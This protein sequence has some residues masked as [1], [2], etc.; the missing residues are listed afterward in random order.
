LHD[1]EAARRLRDEVARLYQDKTGD[2]FTKLGLHELTGI[3]RATLDNWMET[4]VMPPA[5]GMAKLA[6]RLGTEPRRLWAV[7]HGLAPEPA[8]DRIATELG[9]LRRALSPQAEFVEGWVRAQ[10][11]SSSLLPTDADP[12]TPD[13]SSPPR[14]DP[15]SPRPD[16]S[17]SPRHRGRQ[18]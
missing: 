11:Q 5:E 17:E 16:V 9:L 3:G 15:P 1:T 14:A 12:G 10:D 18:P 6:D 7:W 8:L 4:G 2:R 13:G